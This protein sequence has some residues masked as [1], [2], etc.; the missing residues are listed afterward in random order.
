MD[1]L[2]IKGWSKIRPDLKPAPDADE[3]Q[4]NSRSPSKSVAPRIPRLSDDPF[5][6]VSGTRKRGDQISPEHILISGATEG[7]AV[8]LGQLVQLLGRLVRGI[9]RIEG[10]LTGGNGIHAT[11]GTIHQGPLEILHQTR[12]GNDAGVW[13]FLLQ[14]RNCVS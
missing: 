7:T 13:L 11:L 2:R 4:Q 1:A 3:R 9:P 6:G 5:D 10:L 8:L 12:G 14:N